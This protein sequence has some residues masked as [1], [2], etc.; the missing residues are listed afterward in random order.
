[1]RNSL[2]T[3]VGTIAVAGLL[4]GCASGGSGNEGG[5]ANG[6]KDKSSGSKVKIEFYQHK[7]EAVAI[8]DK[9]IADFEAKNPGITVEQNNRPNDPTY[10]KSRAAAND[11]PDVIGIVGSADFT[12]YV[13]G[14][15]IKDV[16]GTP[17][18]D[19]IQVSFQDQL[20]AYTGT[21]EL[22]AYP[23]SAN[24]Q[25]VLYNKKMFA[26]AGLKIPTTWDELIQLCET[27]QQKGGQPFVFGYKDSWTTNVP[28]NQLGGTLIPNE[29]FDQLAE[30][31]ATFADAWKETLN[32]SLELN[33]YGNKNVVE[34]GYDQANAEFATGKSYMYIQ[35]IWAIAPVKAKNPDIELG[36]FPLPAA[37]KAEETKIIGGIDQILAI[38]KN[39]KNVEAAEKFVAFLMEKENAQ[40]FIQDQK[41]LPTIQGVVQNDPSL[42]DLQP[43]LDKGLVGATVTDRFIP[44]YNPND[45]LQEMMMKGNVEETLAKM[46]KEYTKISGR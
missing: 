10:L 4:A 18:A 43:L 44:G 15:L 5:T 20:K 36:A 9:L 16:S 13:K 22:Y 35:G 2:K 6:T 41:L 3:V 1:M 19:T 24:A 14:G 25:T 8:Y 38:S 31:K 40:T 39:S 29:F 7:S 32:K 28:I 45:F 34:Y 42:S 21:K 26:E 33:K 46:D 27:I 12:S 37:N 11:L 23:Y 30:G 17:L